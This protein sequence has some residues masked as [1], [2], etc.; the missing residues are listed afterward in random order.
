MTENSDQTHWSVKAA[1]RYLGIAPSTLYGW[2]NP[3]SGTKRAYVIGDKPPYIRFG[4]N[5]I[6]LP[7]EEFKKWADSYR[8]RT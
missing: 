1:A 8:K 3:E 5:S 4:R 2:L 6:R 7:I